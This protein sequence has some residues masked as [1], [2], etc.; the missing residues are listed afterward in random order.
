MLQ[1][2]PCNFEVVLHGKDEWTAFSL[3]D[4]HKELE[5]ALKAVFPSAN[6]RT[7]ICRA[8]GCY[9]CMVLSQ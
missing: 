5:A 9:D 4:K 1:Q 6:I 2:V 7:S 8:G 3:M